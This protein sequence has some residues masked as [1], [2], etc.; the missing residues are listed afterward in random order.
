MSL[1]HLRAYLS[2]NEYYGSFDMLR[3]LAAIATARGARILTHLA[4]IRSGSLHVRILEQPGVPVVR[5]VD[6]SMPDIVLY[7]PVCDNGAFLADGSVGGAVP[8]AIVCVSDDPTYALMAF[9]IG[10]LHY[11]SYDAAECDLDCA[12][13]RCRLVGAPRESSMFL[14]EVQSPFVPSHDVIALPVLS[15]IELRDRRSIVRIQGERNY[16]RIVFVSDPEIILSR[17][18]RDYAPALENSG[19]LRVH[20][21]HL[22]NIVHV[23]RI[24]RGKTP[25]LVMCNGDEVE[26]SATYREQLYAAVRM[27]ERRVT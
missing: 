21:S 22:V 9:Q 18:I 14:R 23:R 27:V 13:E 8:P 10:A 25:R 5:A 7:D 20:R 6:Q 16:T 4:A 11:L 12:L 24:V 2:I 15:G 17:T 3:I 19:L 26:V 1:C